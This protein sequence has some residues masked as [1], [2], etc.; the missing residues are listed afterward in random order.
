MY[1]EL[2]DCTQVR[3]RPTRVPS[4]LNVNREYI[5]SVLQ[6]LVTANFV[7]SSLIRSISSQRASVASYG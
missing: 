7:S 3:A 2:Q 6:L 5:C 1:A 4:M